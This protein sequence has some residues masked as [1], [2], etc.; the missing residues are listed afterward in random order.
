[1]ADAP[2]LHYLL[3][4]GR[5]LDRQ[6]VAVSLELSDVEDA[7]LA[8]QIHANGLGRAVEIWARRD[9]APSSVLHYIDTVRPADRTYRTR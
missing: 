8:A 6:P 4:T 9:A 2:P 5:K 3:F 1:M 7:R